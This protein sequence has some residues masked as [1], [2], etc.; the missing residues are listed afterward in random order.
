MQC[1]QCPHSENFPS[2]AIELEPYL[3]I[4]M[5]HTFYP[6]VEQT[7]RIDVKADATDA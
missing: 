3:D 2:R 1:M 7:Y 6:K 5:G 4:A